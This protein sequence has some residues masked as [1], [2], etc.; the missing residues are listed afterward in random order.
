MEFYQKYCTYT[1]HT[2]RVYSPPKVLLQ[3]LS[4]IFLR[5]PKQYFVFVSP[6]KN[7]PTQS[8]T[9]VLTLWIYRTEDKLQSCILVWRDSKKRCVHCI[10]ADRSHVRSSQLRGL[11]NGDLHFAHLGKFQKLF[12]DQGEIIS[13]LGYSTSFPRNQKQQSRNRVRQLQKLK[14]NFILSINS[15]RKSIEE[16]SFLAPM[17]RLAIFSASCE[18]LFFL[19]P[20]R[21]SSRCNG[22]AAKSIDEENYFV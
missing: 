13:N 11:C 10:L 18:Y 1:C 15:P 8:A 19:N 3:P 12:N 9:I 20:P 2:V 21:Q 16:Y 17:L 5:I 14:D 7:K 22:E 6:P 4:Q